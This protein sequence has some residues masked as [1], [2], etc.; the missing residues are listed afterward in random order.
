MFV[1]IVRHLPRFWAIWILFNTC[2]EINL[3]LCLSISLFYWYIICMII[4]RIHKTL[5]C[6]STR[7]PFAAPAQSCPRAVERRDSFRIDNPPHD[8]NLCRWW[9]ASPGQMPQLPTAAGQCWWHRSGWYNPS[10]CKSPRPGRWGASSTHHIEIYDYLSDAP[11]SVN[12]LGIYIYI[13]IST[14]LKIL[15]QRNGITIIHFIDI[16]NFLFGPL[17]K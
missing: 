6:H 12:N 11:C 2:I 8:C 5:A 3:H 16:Q 15:N 1:E 14:K 17:S 13:N 9:V 10:Y 4:D 7:P